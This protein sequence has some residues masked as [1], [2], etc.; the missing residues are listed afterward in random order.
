MISRRLCPG[1]EFADMNVFL[2]ASSIISTMNVAKALD[3]TGQEITPLEDFTSGF[4][5]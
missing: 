5:R 3:E 1:R 4:V 2:V